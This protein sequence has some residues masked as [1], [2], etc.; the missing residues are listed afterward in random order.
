M[1]EHSIPFSAADARGSLA[2]LPEDAGVF[3]LFAADPAAEPYLSKAT[4]LR[5]RLMRFLSPQPGQSRR[6]QLAGMVARIEYTPTGSDLESQLVLYRASVAA[7]GDRASKKLHLRAPAFLRMAMQNAYPRVYVTTK[8]TKS[9]ED[10]LFGPFPSRFAAERFGEEA[11]NL[12]LLRRC[13]EDLNPDPAFPGC[14]YSEMKMCLAPCFKGC[15]DER[16]AEEVA[17]VRQFLATRGSSL[18]KQLEAERNR[19]SEALEFERA[20]QIH[21][22]MQK[23]EAVAGLA[24]EIVRPLSELHAVI[25][26]PS[27]EPLQVAVFRVRKGLLSGPALYSTIGMR[28]PNEQS[29]SSSLF[30]HPA[31]I[32]P[33]PLDEGLQNAGEPSASVVTASR[34]VLEQRLDDVLRELEASGERE[35]KRAR[36]ETLAAHLSLL[37]RWYYRPA[38]RRVGEIYFAGED[39]VFPRKAILRGISRVFRTGRH[40]PESGKTQAADSSPSPL[41]GTLDSSEKGAHSAF[42]NEIKLGT[43]ID[44]GLKHG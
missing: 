30:A 23:V 5:R 24:S 3:A 22:R 9:A 13:H 20:A 14:A 40:T 15:T 2:A 28:H 35:A 41:T 39:G 19:A 38:A 21:A 37:T 44:S 26:Q 12:F 34:D 11:L 7:F 6:L 1:L 10:S 36:Q 16:Y 17:A 31:A 27:A 33:V 8:V 42:H 18:L 29:G 4:N 25:L 43:P 32:Q